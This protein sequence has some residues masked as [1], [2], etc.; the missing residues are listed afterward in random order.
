M[1]T[2]SELKAQ[3]RRK[4]GEAP[5]REPVPIAAAPV[6]QVRVPEAEP[7]EPAGA[8][9]AAPPWSGQRIQIEDLADFK[10]RWRLRLVNI[11]WPEDALCPIATFAPEAID[12]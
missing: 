12:E 5:P 1:T 11:V 4:M 6:E 10:K 9:V 7:A 3:H 8:C 2:L